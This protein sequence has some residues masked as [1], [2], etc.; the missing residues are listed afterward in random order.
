MATITSLG[1]KTTSGIQA[2]VKNW[3][4]KIATDDND[5]IYLRKKNGILYVMKVEPHFGGKWEQLDSLDFPVISDEHGKKLVESLANLREELV[6]PAEPKP[7][8]KIELGWYQDAN[9]NLY[10]YTGQGIWDAPMS[11]WEKL[12][13]LADS[14]TLEFLG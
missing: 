11:S 9:A 6:T 10:K 1:I 3:A 5:M 8:P 13:N 7:I 14:G 4:N 12:L 2:A